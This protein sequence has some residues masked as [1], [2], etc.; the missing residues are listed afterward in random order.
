MHAVPRPLHHHIIGIGSHRFVA[1]HREEIGVQLGVI[2]P[3]FLRQIQ[4][5]GDLPG[6]Q[7]LDI[8]LIKGPF[9]LGV[10]HL[11]VK[12][13]EGRG[14]S[15]PFPGAVSAHPVID[16][17]DLLGAAFSRQIDGLEQLLGHVVHILIT[18]V[19][20]GLTIGQGGKGAHGEQRQ[21]HPQGQDQG[22]K[23]F[24]H[25]RSLTFLCFLSF[26]WCQ[27]VRRRSGSHSTSFSKVRVP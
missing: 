19:D 11:R 17:L 20:G 12:G 22:G 6:A 13:G 3:P 24:F 16:G 5:Q 26:L 25:D 21:H 8:L 2:G 15:L 1:V 10:H 9:G 27:M 7:I 4:A 14:C 18:G 23:S